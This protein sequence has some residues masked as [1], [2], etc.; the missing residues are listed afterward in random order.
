MYGKDMIQDMKGETSGHYKKLLVALMDDRPHFDAKCLRA[1]MK[2]SGG[3]C[4]Y[5]R[6]VQYPLMFAPIIPPQRA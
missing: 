4:S 3:L 6:S 2:V 1:A 5:L